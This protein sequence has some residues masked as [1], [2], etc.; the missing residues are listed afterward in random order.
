MNWV[1]TASNEIARP[2]YYVTTSD[3]WI[4][5]IQYEYIEY[6]EDIYTGE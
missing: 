3:I 1:S 6:E 5:E 4:S 2:E